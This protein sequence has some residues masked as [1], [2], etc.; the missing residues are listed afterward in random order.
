MTAEQYLAEIR[1]LRATFDVLSEP[2]ELFDDEA[3]RVRAALDDLIEVCL[4]GLSCGANACT[5]RPGES[6]TD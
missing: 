4:L 3:E 6:A 2:P 1:K 5:F